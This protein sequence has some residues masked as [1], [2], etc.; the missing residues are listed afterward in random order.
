MELI[1]GLMNGQV[2]QRNKRNVCE[3]VIVGRSD[4]GGI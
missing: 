3:T 1:A 4:A 2:L